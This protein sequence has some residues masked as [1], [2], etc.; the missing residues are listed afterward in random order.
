MKAARPDEWLQ[1][2][3]I[4]PLILPSRLKIEHLNGQQGWNEHNIMFTSV[5]AERFNIQE[6]S[7]R[8]E[9]LDTRREMEV[10]RWRDGG[11]EMERW[12]NGGGERQ[13]E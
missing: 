4:Q 6:P 12:R 1:H 7:R 5:P 8:R 11:G 10:E 3:S 2:S 13:V 9:W